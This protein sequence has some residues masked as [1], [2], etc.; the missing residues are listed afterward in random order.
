[1]RVY[2]FDGQASMD[3]GVRGGIDF[4]SLAIK[5]DPTNHWHH[6]VPHATPYMTSVFDKSGSINGVAN[7]ALT[8]SVKLTFARM[9]TYELD[10]VPTV[11]SHLTADLNSKQVCVDGDLHLEAAQAA[12]LQINVAILNIHKVSTSFLYTHMHTCI[13]P[14]RE[15]E[16]KSDQSI[17]LYETR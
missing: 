5:Y 17:Y 8:P 13:Y 4:G 10:F 9:L 2:S 6:D 1:M 11:T 7:F 15:E 16:K 14:M 3:L 12:E